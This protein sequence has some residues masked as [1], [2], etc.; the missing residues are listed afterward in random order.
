MT[1]NLIA[2]LVS[3]AF[4]WFIFVS[5]YRVYLSLKADNKD[6]LSN[7]KRLDSEEDEVNA[8]KYFLNKVLT[9]YEELEQEKMLL[10]RFLERNS[11][12][13][14]Q[15]GDAYEKLEIYMEF[16]F[17]NMPEDK[18]ESLRPHYHEVKLMLAERF[19][20]L[21][22]QRLSTKMTYSSYFEENNQDKPA[23]LETIDLSLS[24]FKLK[25]QNNKD[26]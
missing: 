25:Q 7:A 4:V 16:K 26:S 23:S 10:L 8:F 1:D 18:Q 21:L 5:I 3:I 19:E 11:D 6:V 12:S 20:A 17:L 13:L 9:S 22:N 24:L 14:K 2:I 15:L